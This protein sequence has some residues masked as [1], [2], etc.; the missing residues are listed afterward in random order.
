VFPIGVATG[1]AMWV[2]FGG[3]DRATKWFPTRRGLEIERTCQ[4]TKE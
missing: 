3:T 4:P 1:A 2:V